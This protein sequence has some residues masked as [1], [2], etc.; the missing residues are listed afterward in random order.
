MTAC[1]IEYLEL[2]TPDLESAVDFFAC[3]IGLTPVQS[4]VTAG[5]RSTLLR[6]G[7]LRMLVTTGPATRQYVEAHGEGIAVIGLGCDDVAATRAAAAEA[8]AAL[9]GDVVVPPGYGDTHYR[10][11]SCTPSTDAPQDHATARVRC[12]DHIAICLEAATMS[13]AARFYADAFGLQRYS[14]E[15]V[16]FGEQAMDSIVVRSPLGGVT[17]TLI[18]PDPS[19]RPGQIDAFLG[20]NRGPGVQHV[21]F[22]VDDI[23]AAVRAY[24]DNGIS[25]L[26]TPGSYYDVLA[27]RVGPMAEAVADLRDTHVL[28]DRDEWGYL[29]Q[30]FTR[31]PYQRETLFFELIQRHGARGFGSA[32]IRALYEAVERERQIT[33]SGV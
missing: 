12:V 33:R 6:Q 24:R 22:L 23:V 29:L 19:R 32:N 1:N 31:S 2:Y 10:L 3:S 8:G 26:P 28:A 14:G 25:F 20:R 13:S 17:F 15:F 9:H 16:A 18:E 7:G 11:L 4:Y 30:I 5:R 21:A 27:A